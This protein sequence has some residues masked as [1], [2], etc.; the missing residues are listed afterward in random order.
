MFDYL[1]TNL[2][3]LFIG[4]FFQECLTRNS[5]DQPGKI[6]HESILK[7]DDYRLYSV[8]M[9]NNYELIKDDE[10]LIKNEDQN[11]NNLFYNL[12]DQLINHAPIDFWQLNINH[13][14]FTVSPDY[15]VQV[16]D[17][18]LNNSLNFDL[19]GK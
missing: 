19:L 5:T 1:I 2:V 6:E 11:A 17:Y 4:L 7:Y 16:E 14:L 13:S 3:I 8:R 12:M 9:P 15:Y 10:L 18:L